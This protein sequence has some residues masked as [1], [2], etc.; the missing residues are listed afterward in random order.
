MTIPKR[1]RINPSFPKRQILLTLLL[2]TA[3]G[4]ILPAENGPGEFVLQ[5][6]RFWIPDSV[7]KEEYLAVSAPPVRV[8][9]KIL[10]LNYHNIVLG[11]TG[12]EYNRDLYN[13]EQ[14]LRFLK[15]RYEIIDL[16]DL[17]AIREGRRG[18]RHDAVILTF[19][20]GDLSIYALAYPLLREYRI[21]A[22][23]FIIS[24]FAGHVGYAD[25]RQIREISD[26]RTDEGEQLFTI[27]SHSASH[28][29]LSTLEPEVLLRELSESRREIERNIDRKVD[30]LALPFGDGADNPQIINAAKAAGYSGIRTT[31]ESVLL[32]SA[33]E[34]YSLSCFTIG[35]RSSD[36]EMNRIW[37]ASGR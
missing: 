13:F 31:R 3:V 20:D 9:P 5:D 37:K 34:P 2:L 33:I 12:N 1:T 8:H 19:D 36:P 10:I 17:L 6:I 27:G 25:W 30:F 14:D 32:P 11:R 35:N 15:Q 21:K 16:Q 4:G 26:Y 23:F 7:Q 24:S 22:T 28:Q 29:F 18:L